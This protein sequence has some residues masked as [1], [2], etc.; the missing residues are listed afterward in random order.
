MSFETAKLKVEGG[1]AIPFA[2]NPT[3]YSI[4][5]AN[6]FKGDPKPG[7]DRPEVDFT[8][9]SPQE[10]SVE[11]FLD[12]LGSGK[13]V[14][15]HL[16]ALYDAMQVNT[17]FSKPKKKNSGR[18]PKVTFEWGQTVFEGFIKTLAVKHIR[19]SPS[20][21][22]TRATVTLTI[23]QA[24]DRP[25]ATGPV[26]AGQNP[27]TRALPD[28]GAHVLREGDT[29]QAVA[30]DVYGDPNQWREL[31]AANGIDDPLRLRRGT[32]LALPGMD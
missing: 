29:L 17:K 8:G 16:Q 23:I 26:P 30:T 2:F 25:K 20:G 32:M 13:G 27:T 15:G 21:A 22:T 11:M 24:A 1:T 31:A 10:L 18:P 28:L 5:R 4:N 7:I 9:G 14:D 12:D 6:G 3:E 19:F